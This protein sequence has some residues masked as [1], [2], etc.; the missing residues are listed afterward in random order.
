MAY[1]FDFVADLKF[2]CRLNVDLGFVVYTR[3]LVLLLYFES[4][5][6]V[7]FDS[8]F[9]ICMMLILIVGFSVVDVFV[10]ILVLIWALL[11]MPVIFDSVFGRDVGFDVDIQCIVDVGVDDGFG[12][13]LMLILILMFVLV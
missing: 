1:V 7:G 6:D 9:L 4:R 8:D 3:F 2:E 10:S 5:F 13:M 12:M 11:S